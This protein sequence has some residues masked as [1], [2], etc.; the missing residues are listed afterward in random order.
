MAKQVLKHE[1][2]G[3][4]YTRQTARNYTY[5]V[6]AKENKQRTISWAQERLDNLVSKR[7]RDQLTADETYEWKYNKNFLATPVGEYYYYHRDQGGAYMNR[8][9]KHM[10]V[11]QCWK[12]MILENMPESVEAKVQDTIERLSAQA[13]KDMD[14]AIAS[15]PQWGVYSWHGTA[16]NAARAAR[17]LE[18]RMHTKVQRINNGEAPK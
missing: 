1:L 3:K 16:D 9:G 6:I 10:L 18:D 7:F 13:A 8:A 17:A 11:E 12:D 15:D 14:A 5:V 4:V 2:E